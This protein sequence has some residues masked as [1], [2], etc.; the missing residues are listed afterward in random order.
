MKK[1]NSLRNAW[2]N[3]S[4]DQRY[5]I[6]KLYYLPQDFM[7]KITGKSHKYVPPR[8][9]IYTGSPASGEKYYNQ[10]IHQIQL[11]K[12]FIN[13]NSEDEVLDIGSGVGRSAMVLT[14]LLNKNS[15]YEGFD[16]VKKGVDWCNK[17]IKKDFPNFNFT[18]VP[19]FNDLYNK[20]K[21]DATQFVFPYEDAS[22]DKIF[23]FS[24]FTHMK[25]AEIEHY[26]TEINRVMKPDGLSLHTFFLYDDND[27]EY[28]SSLKDFNFPIDRGNHKL[29]SDK[30]ESANIAIH[31]N[32]LHQMAERSGL[33]IV[34][35]IDGFWKAE[36]REN[37][38]NDYQDT[39]VFKKKQ[40]LF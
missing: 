28:I 9:Y 5:F 4:A 14:E 33:E 3:L 1:T 12:N 10:G 26:F 27:A 22:F 34:S 15:R 13:L 35:I 38:Q 39:I 16:V 23:S 19:L 20:E 36:K 24:V 40:Y 2:Y 21:K 11:M 7:D 29:M 31:K 6:R 8:G 25:M 37:S 18:Y 32:E 30:V 17:K